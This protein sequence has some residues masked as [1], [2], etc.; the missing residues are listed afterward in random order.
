MA[1]ISGMDAEK[2]A[3]SSI[4]PPAK[5]NSVISSDVEVDDGCLVYP[6]DLRLEGKKGVQ[7]VLIDA[8]NGN[9]ISSKFEGQ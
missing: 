5:V 3:V 4:P 9:V 1:K 7:E 6:I 8:G 2:K